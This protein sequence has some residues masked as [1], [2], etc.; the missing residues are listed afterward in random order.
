MQW[1]L[2]ALKQYPF[3]S[4]HIFFFLIQKEKNPPSEI[5]SWQLY[6]DW[7]TNTWL[8]LWW[9]LGLRFICLLF[10]TSFSFFTRCGSF[11]RSF[12]HSFFTTI[13]CPV[14]WKG[15]NKQLCKISSLWLW[16]L[17]VVWNWKFYDYL[18][19]D[20]YQIVFLLSPSF[21]GQKFT[22]D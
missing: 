15:F 11:G 19:N 8:I 17:Q 21:L 7:T 22:T 14:D 16:F 20:I 3:P 6:T 13:K 5:T 4:W 2:L 12:F 18:M 9:K 10:T 1:T